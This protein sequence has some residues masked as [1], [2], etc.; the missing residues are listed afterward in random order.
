[1]KKYIQP[2][3][4]LEMSIFRF[5]KY[6]I[7]SLFTLGTLFAAL[8]AN[9]DGDL[10][11]D[12]VTAYNLVVDQNIESSGNYSPGAFY[13]GAK[14][15][16]D[17]L[18]DLADV[19]VRA[20][21]FLAGTPG[22]YP[23][24][25][26]DE[27]ALGYSYAGDFSLTHQASTE[28]ATRFLGT[29]PAG[30]C[31]TVYWLV[32]YPRVDVN[33]NSVI[34]AKNNT[35]DD[36]RLQ[37]DI[38]ATADDGGVSRAADQSSFVTCRNELG[39][40]A[41]KVW[42][43]NNNKVPAEFVDI[44]DDSLGWYTN[45]N[46]NI[47]TVCP[48]EE[49]IL[50]K[51]IW[52]D[53]GN[54]NKGFD[55]DGDRIPDNNAWMQPV[56]DPS[57][58]N[59]DCYRLVRTYGMIIISLKRGG[60]HIIQ[61]EDELYF[62]DIPPNTNGVG[63][64]V[65]EYAVLDGPCSSQLTPYQEVAS[66]NNNEKFNA[67]FGVTLPMA[68]SEDPANCLDFQ[69]TASPSRL[70]VL[71]GTVNY[72][73]SV[74][75]LST[76]DIGQAEY[77]LP[78]VIRETIPANTDYI[79][80]TAAL[81]NTLPLGLSGY[82][83]LYSVDN[84]DTWTATEP[85]P[86]NTVTD[87]QWWLDDP[88]PGLSTAAVT[89]QVSVAASYPDLT[90]PNT[91][92]ASFGFT[93][94]FAEDTAQVLIGGNNSICGTVFGD[95]GG[96]TGA[97]WNKVMDG[98]EA[99]LPD[100][101]VCVY[102]DAN[103]D[104][105]LVLDT[106]NGQ[107]ELEEEGIQGG[108]IDVD[109]YSAIAPIG[110]G[111]TDGHVHAYDDKYDVL[112]VDF[113]NFLSNNLH[114]I[115][116]DITDGNQKFKLIIA[117]ADLSP[118]GRLVINNSYSAT[119][120]GTYI[121][122]RDYDN[123]ALADLDI[124]SLNGVAGSTQLFE[125]GMYFD[126][127]TI[128]D[129]N[130]VP[131]NTGDVRKN[132]PGLNGE[133]RNGAL[134]IQAVAVDPAGSDVFT[135]DPSLSAG[136]V[137]GVATSGLLWESTIFW[138]WDGVSYHQNYSFTPGDGIV[139]SG[140]GGYDYL[141][142]CIDTDINGDYCFDLLID[143]NYL[144]VV[145]NYDADL[146]GGYVESTDITI[147][148]DLDVNSQDA[149]GLTETGHDFGFGPPLLVNKRLVTS[150]PAYEG[151]TLGFSITV[152]N[153]S[154][155]PLA[156]I[157]LADTFDAD[158]L[159]FLYAIP[160]PTTTSTGG[161]SP[162]TNTG[163]LEWDNI[164]AVEG[165][166]PIIYSSNIPKADNL[167][168]YWTFNEGTG[169]TASDYS[170]N[171][172]HGTLQ[173]SPIWSSGK[174][175][176][177]LDFTNAYVEIPHHTDFNLVKGTFAAWVNADV[178]IDNAGIITKGTTTY[179]YSMHLAWPVAN[180]NFNDDNFRFRTNV[181][182][183]SI[184]EGESD[185]EFFPG[186]WHHVAVTFDGKK[187]RFYL[188]GVEDG[189]QGLD[190]LMTNLES[191]ILGANLPAGSYFDGKLDE[192]AIYNDVLTEAEI[193]E[194][195][196]YNSLDI[197]LG[198]IVLNWPM[199]EGSGTVVN[200]LSGKGITG[201]TVDGP[202]WAV[203]QVGTYALSFDGIDDHVI[204]ESI[205]Q[206]LDSMF[207]MSFWVRS[208]AGGVQYLMSN[209]VEL[210]DSTGEWWISTN[211]GGL[212]DFAWR[213]GGSTPN[214]TAGSGVVN[215]GSWHHVF[216]NYNGT[217]LSIYRDGTQVG[218][219]AASINMPPTFAPIWL[220]RDTR[221]NTD[222]FTG[223]LDHIYIFDDSM[224]TSEI[225]ELYLSYYPAYA[226][227][228]GGCP[229][230][231]GSWD[232]E[233]GSGTSTQDES[234]MGMTGTLVNSPA[235][236]PGQNGRHALDFSGA[237]LEHVDLGSTDFS[238]GSN[239]SMAFWLK[240]DGSDFRET[241]LAKGTQ[242]TAGH[243][244]LYLN[245]GELRFRTDVPATID[246]SSGYLFDDDT[247]HH[248]VVN[249]NGG[250]LIFYVDGQSIASSAQSFTVPALTASMMIGRLV[251]A[252]VNEFNSQLDQ[253]KIYNC[254]L[255]QDQ[256]TR[257]IETGTIEDLENQE[258][259]VYFLA[260][261]PAGFSVGTTN[262]V[263]VSGAQFTDGR[264][265][266]LSCD[267]DLAN[268]TIFNTGTA[269][270]TIWADVD[271]DGWQG[272]TGQ[273]A[274]EGGIPGVRV[275][276]EGCTDYLGGGACNVPTESDTVTTDANGD[277]E[278]TGLRHGTHY[279][280]YVVT[281]D[282][283][284]AAPT[285]TGDPDDDPIRGSGNGG[286]CGVGAGNAPCDDAWDNGGNWFEMM[287]DTWGTEDEEL[288]ELNFGYLIT[289]S[290][291]GVV[292]NDI[293]SDGVRDG[294]EPFLEN[295]V[296]QLSS[297]AFT[298]TDANGIYAFANVVP[299]T[300]SVNVS[301]PSL[302]LGGAWLQTGESDATVNNFITV[303][304]SSGVSSGSHEFGFVATGMSML[305]DQLYFDWDG[306][307]NQD[308][309]EEGIPNITV[310][311]YRDIN[312]NGV[313]D[314][315]DILLA[316]TVTASD[317]YYEFTS[318]PMGSYLVGVDLK[319][320]DFPQASQTADPDE[321]G[322]C[323]TCDSWAAAYLNGFFPDDF[324]DFGYRPLGAATVGD[325]VFLDLNADGLAGNIGENGIPSISVE[326]HVDL[327]QDGTFEK[328]YT[329]QTNANGNYFFYNLPNGNYR[330]IVDSTDSNLPIDLAGFPY[331]LTTAGVLSFTI[332]NG[333]ITQIDG[334]PCTA[335]NLDVDFGFT[336]LGM[337]GDMVYWDANNNGTQD[338]NEDGVDGV[339]VYLC[340]GDVACGSGNAIATTT[341]SDG[342]DGRPIGYF[343]FGAL[344]AGTYSIGV[345]TASGPL[346]GSVQTADPNSDGFPC[347]DPDLVLLGYPA[348]DNNFSLFLP[349]GSLYSGADFGY[350]PTGVIGDYIWFDQDGDGV[351]DG[352]EIG[353]P[354]VQI[355]LCA[356]A[357]VCDG[358]NAIDSTTTD[359]DGNYS[360]DGVVDGTY[361]ITINPPAGYTA[362]VGSE[363]L[364]DTTATIVMSGT[365]ITSINGSACA[366][367]DLNVDFGYE[368]VGPFSL[369]GTVCLDDGSV[370][371]VCTG[372]GGENPQQFMTMYLYDA[373]NTLIGFTTTD[374]FGDYSF[375]NVTGGVYTV[376]MIRILP[377]LD[378]ATLTT[379]NAD[380][381]AG[382]TITETFLTVSITLP[383][384]G[385]VSDVDFAYYIYTDFDFGDL[386]SP[387]STTSDVNPIGAYHRL[388]P[389]PTLY[390]GS[391][392]DSEGNGI[393]SGGAV[394]DDLDNTDDEDGVTFINQFGWSEGD[395]GTGNGGTVDVT[396]NGTGHLIAW[397][398]FNKDGD[399][400]DTGEMIISEPVGT[401]TQTYNFGIPYGT[402]L[403]GEFFF[404]F[405]LFASE[406]VIP[407]AS[408]YG[409][410]YDGEVEDY[411]LS[412]APLPVELLAFQAVREGSDGKINWTTTDAVEAS[413]FELER[414]LDGHN[415][416]PLH[417]EKARGGKGENHYQ[418]L[419][420]NIVDLGA[421]RL[422]Y[423]LKQV[424][425]NGSFSYSQT[426]EI[427]L[428]NVLQLGMDVY[429]NPADKQ[430]QIS[431]L[432]RDI[433]NPE[434]TLVN[435]LGK[436]L[437]QESVPGGQERQQVKLDVSNF[438]AGVYYLRLDHADGQLIR[439]VVIQ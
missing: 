24:E 247:W 238:L 150:N 224:S 131:T 147:S 216:V 112:G 321:S 184:D 252:G 284:D 203:G 29:I 177:A 92:Y 47:L 365:V 401:G 163:L 262:S 315:F 86:A 152:A 415:F 319:D 151:D 68:N 273:E 129:G 145:D 205:S 15:C 223:E 244:Q 51:G 316:T 61:F 268:V 427:G 169:N 65:Y 149:S 413:R 10:R 52:Y 187:A 93:N 158:R 299:G 126:V 327:N 304:V 292:W 173:S 103:N 228:G 277:Y 270:G 377:P 426:V 333:A 293:D 288:T 146:P 418:Y 387:Y 351:Q 81:G 26:V 135:T 120:P 122:V 260:K 384:L 60:Y 259:L 425:E 320:P 408:Y 172:H 314:P 397:V 432:T 108:H 291:Y 290:I 111:T 417:T 55:N 130:L 382:G 202:T 400:G 240:S 161:T 269:A 7:A 398:D 239:F 424:D 383:V 62:T 294:D 380:V 186:E 372:I 282:I 88:L 80:G 420:R 101:Q 357:G 253:L 98:D 326:L 336:R 434:L 215:D 165:T 395:P 354:N 266:N 241:L 189:D 256:I 279:Q 412:F 148:V 307:A 201:T 364:G 41:N 133:W 271:G 77:D 38:W 348:C 362:T 43:S 265:A 1:M 367:C 325:Q 232:F 346:A 69:K 28:D 210:A 399:F 285:L 160:D 107:N 3:N 409:I 46:N 422:Y 229:Q 66:G 106:G 83:I 44:I 421:S 219:F 18:N 166:E 225:N 213:N 257:L 350:Q 385:N 33:N 42:P 182:L 190:D 21:D 90:I 168:G 300:Y 323:Q 429:P 16:N 175:G 295:V 428:E 114:E 370:D 85:V 171:S 328:V 359:S 289:G 220:A 211:A 352:G 226:P 50:A 53:L 79:A 255:N 419:D 39:A 373:T 167:I 389:I 308:P 313:K 437:W 342:T 99:G 138:H 334:T 330:M 272:A 89:F 405:R 124:F 391:T 236:I 75:N 356:G 276:I 9:P 198:N 17:G 58:F 185:T 188:D 332:A 394:G 438:A 102:V 235:W 414:S 344:D 337:I 242:G 104:G 195:M 179:P 139:S 207:S 261:D 105:N 5:L 4:S 82:S 132:E 34:G 6:A 22:I 347:D 35:N 248:V 439:K 274:G 144:V 227:F 309:N 183:G 329:D 376:S 264:P 361:R 74:E 25:S 45:Q 97:Q 298:S 31:V 250:A 164:G 386:P 302:P 410:A 48:G 275:V 404:R 72:S 32:S 76:A 54:I 366:N 155:L 118:G 349:Q 411:M 67:D 360:F 115:N 317:G 249:Y 381:P 209:D 192:V 217:N 212:I 374:A 59:A 119:N 14:I 353:L 403:T 324:V 263:C 91:A 123:T 141:I 371:G 117:N 345:E 281:A 433:T 100:V 341:T 37:Y 71:P 206:D 78:I 392:V 233:E 57:L 218:N 287:V 378:Q 197:D 435:T 245:F 110:S 322:V 11:I 246:Q 162:F 431:L 368:V 180:G 283:P 113:F 94:P 64:V 406:P 136:G 393:V 318:L 407:A 70:P 379:T 56:G 343:R 396:V 335:C 416:S 310:W 8:A 95:D 251:G 243:F 96:T 49:N 267:V 286:T 174:Y 278:F 234:G 331:S 87:I 191:L 388:D 116:Q 375:G 181:G 296:V 363:S 358:T 20:G 137:Q 134:T 196:R 23:I 311:L 125:L 390:L 430:L 2:F 355:Y 222:H 312:D 214:Y 128:Y 339:T 27:V 369:S 170:G 231:V 156:L 178:M 338:L 142:D 40:S 36:L 297:G 208:S 13:I 19:V 237:S 423:R 305:G 154:E 12:V 109:T 143:G 436:E 340:N 204:S 193:G 301:I 303:T 159:D 30:E 84:G 280:I 153:R 140:V 127:N 157:P 402:V 230:L 258:V 121:P 199:E 200:D 73:L 63:F 306:D 254:S 176:N 221:A 194:L